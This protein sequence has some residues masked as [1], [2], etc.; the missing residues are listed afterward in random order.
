MGRCKEMDSLEKERNNNC[1]EIS[2]LLKNCRGQ[3]NAI[4]SSIEAGGC[5]GEVRDSSTA[6]ILCCPVSLLGLLNFT[7]KVTGKH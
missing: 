7:A 6:Q 3:H 2:Y 1:K 4:R 5:V